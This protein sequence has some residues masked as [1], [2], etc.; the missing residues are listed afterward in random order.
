M[1]G[2][3]ALEINATG[4]MIPK[5]FFSFAVLIAECGLRESNHQPSSTMFIIEALHPD[6]W[7]ERGR[8][9]LEYWAHQEA[10]VRCCSDGR[11]YRIL[12]E[13]GRELVALIHTS[14]C[15][16]PV[17]PSPEPAAR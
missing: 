15:R 9:R 14:S 3:S 11:N 8:F 1:S 7:R 4:S 17:R 10:Q 5:H 13:P 2:F 6:G 16:L 12:Q